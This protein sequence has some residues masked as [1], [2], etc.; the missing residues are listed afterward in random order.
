MYSAV[1]MCI[2]VYMLIFIC[3]IAFKNQLKFFTF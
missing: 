1:Y 2:Y 3:I